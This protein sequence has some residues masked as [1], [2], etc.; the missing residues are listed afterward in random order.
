M[1]LKPGY[2]VELKVDRK[3]NFGYFLEAGEKDILLHNNDVVGAVQIGKNIHVFLY[4]DHQERLAATMKE[5]II[6]VG[7]FAWLEAV[8]VRTGHGVFLYNGIS[9][10]LFL[11]MDELPE[12]RGYWPQKGD[13]V[14]VTITWDKRGR[15]MAKLLKGKPIEETAEKAPESLKN[16]EVSG[17]VYHYLDEGALFLTEQGY[18]AFIHNDEMVREPRYGEFVTARV[19]FVRPDGR[20]N[21]TMKGSRTEQQSEDSERIF[22]YLVERGGAMPYTDKTAP[23]DIK[24]RFQLSKAAFKRAL[25]KLMKEGKIEQRDGWTYEKGKK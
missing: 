5:P 16:E 18:L 10:D 23:D 1:E 13:K 6:S 2:M 8:S 21:V 4:L 7:E 11:S 17:H 25:G 3:T 24:A 22:A 14:P 20:V 12:D 9:R 15:M 19:Q